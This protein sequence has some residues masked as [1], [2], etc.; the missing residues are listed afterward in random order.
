MAK[1]ISKYE[2]DLD[3][4]WYDSSNVLYSECVDKEG[5]L[6]QLYITFKDGRT[7]HYFDVD[8]QDYLIFRDG[9]SQGKSLQSI[10]KKYKAEKVEAKDPAVINEQMQ[11]LIEDKLEPSVEI[12]RDE[13][14]FFKGSNIK[15][16]FP[17]IRGNVD[18][19]D[20]EELLT[21]LKITVKKS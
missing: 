13:I 1:I 3:S 18:V 9:S 17:V 14:K 16:S 5:E 2:N 11:V 12:T 21:L 8:V 6:K 7:Y 15:K 4:V 10:I 20:V 19:N